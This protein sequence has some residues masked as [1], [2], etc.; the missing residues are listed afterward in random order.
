M[1]K[2]SVLIIFLILI[3]LSTSHDI[4]GFWSEGDFTAVEEISQPIAIGYWVDK[5]VDQNN[6]IAIFD[7][8][9]PPKLPILRNSVIIYQNKEGGITFYKALRLV[10]PGEES[11]NPSTPNNKLLVPMAYSEDTNE[12]CWY[13]HYKKGHLVVYEGSLYQWASGIPHNPNTLSQNK[14]PHR[15]WVKIDLF[16]EGVNMEDFWFPYQIYYQGNEVYHQ[17]SWYRCLTDRDSN[18]EPK[19]DTD[20]YWEKIDKSSKQ[21]LEE[22]LPTE[23]MKEELL[24]ESL[25]L[26]E[27]LMEKLEE[28]TSLPEQDLSLPEETEEVVEE[29]AEDKIEEMDKPFTEEDKEEE[30]VLEEEIQELDEMKEEEEIE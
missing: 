17:G 6:S 13:H 2:K 21:S 18:K 30:I 16:P 9:N 5:E 23:E 3:L 19:K 8:E 1:K 20:Q 29:T 26:E 14:P 15:S 4:Y 11:F 10:W 25:L 24:E 27:D 28:D 22:T 7:P 12:Y